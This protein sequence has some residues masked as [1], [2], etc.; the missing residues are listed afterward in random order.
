MQFFLNGAAATLSDADQDDLARAVINS[1]FT[2]ARADVD[3]D[4]PGKSREGWWGDTFPDSLGDAFGSK[5]WLLQ[6]AKLT[7]ETISKA[8]DYVE[9]SL[10]WM[11]SDG[12][13]GSVAVEAERGDFDRLDIL[14]VVTKPDA[15]QMTMRFQ[16][17][18]E[19]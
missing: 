8:K 13:A 15:S 11:L 7:D 5:L 14:V 2:W 10:K 1:I 9:E 3:D 4:L 18:W 6:R 12:V 19:R 17:V 16:D